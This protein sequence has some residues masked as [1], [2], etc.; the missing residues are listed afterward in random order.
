MD[1]NLDKDDC[2][3]LPLSSIYFKYL[4]GQ[5]YSIFSSHY[6]SHSHHYYTS[7]YYSRESEA[8]M[9]YVVNCMKPIRSSQYIDASR[10]TTKSNT[11]SPPTSFFYFLDENTV[12]NLNQ[13]CTVEAVVPIMVK[14]ISG[15]STLTIYNKLYEGFYLSWEYRQSDRFPLLQSVN[16]ALH[17]HFLYGV[18]G[19]GFLLLLKEKEFECI[20]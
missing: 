19:I 1:S 17:H 15:M 5:L 10:C 14:N 12:L 20:C 6:Y 18:H 9:M 11:S 8:S 2:N 13:A 7:Y 3:S 4:D 16:R